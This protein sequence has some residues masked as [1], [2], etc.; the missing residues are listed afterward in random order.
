M[1]CGMLTSRRWAI[2]DRKIDWAP[3]LTG[4]GIGV[5]SWL[6][7]VLVDDPLGITTAFSAL[8]GFVAIPLIGVEAVAQNS[9]WKAVPPTLNYGALFLLG[10]ILGSLTSTLAKRKF[11]VETV[12]A[13]WRDRFGP[14]PLRRLSW[15]FFA[16]ALEMYG[17]RMAGGCTSGHALSGGMQLA[18]SSWI[19]TIVIFA[20]GSTA[21]RVMYRGAP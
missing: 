12:P 1:V 10:V 17:A 18:L 11:H 15:V 21:A 5:L 13:V 6:V 14:S 19:F 8:A 16:G 4:A 3:Y 7:F 9:Y 20:T 2:G